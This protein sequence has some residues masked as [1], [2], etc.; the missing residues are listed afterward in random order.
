M[1]IL[2]TL[3]P[4]QV[5]AGDVANLPTA[6]IVLAVDDPQSNLSE[7][8]QAT[9]ATAAIMLAANAPD[10]ET[11]A[12]GAHTSTLQVAAITIGA[13]ALQSQTPGA[14]PQQPSGGGGYMVLSGRRPKK[15]SPAERQPITA[16]LQTVSIGLWTRGP[17][18]ALT[19]ARRTTLPSLAITLGT[20]SP[21]FA[22]ELDPEFE[23]YELD[24]I[25]LFAAGYL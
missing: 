24:V 1:A 2:T 13:N 18:G 15:E 16:N 14:E 8:H 20:H 7:N 22:V 23:S 21:L 9:L 11:V 12:L 10:S 17:V 3:R 6:A 19:E 4:H 25:E 5:V